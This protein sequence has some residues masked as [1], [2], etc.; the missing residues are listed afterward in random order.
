MAQRAALTL[1]LW[2]VRRPP[3]LQEVVF[4]INRGSWVGRWHHA[5]GTAFKLKMEKISS[6]AHCFE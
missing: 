6:D 3:A 4:F 2:V 1:R 5:H